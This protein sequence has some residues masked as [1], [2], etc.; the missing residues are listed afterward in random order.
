M[1]P[2]TT[3]LGL[4][5][6]VIGDRYLY[7]VR[8]GST[9]G[10]PRQSLFLPEC[11]ARRPFFE[12]TMKPETQDDVDR[13][14]KRLLLVGVFLLVGTSIIVLFGLVVTSLP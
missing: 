8:P 13:A 10:P 1:D 3:G 5:P 9:P 6:G 2:W 7:D 12:A 14:S 11:L 4:S